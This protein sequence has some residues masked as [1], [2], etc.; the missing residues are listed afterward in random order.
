MPKMP[1]MPKKR[2][3]QINKCLKGRKVTLLF[4]DSY[5]FGLL[6]SATLRFC[7]FRLYI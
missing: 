6:D 2:N 7:N 4:P 1:K 5:T 3:D